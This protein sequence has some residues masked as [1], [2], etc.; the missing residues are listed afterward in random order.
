MESSNMHEHDELLTGIKKRT[1]D[2]ARFL[3]AAAW[4]RPTPT[5]NAC[6]SPEDL[7]HAE[8]LLG[9]PFPKFIRRMYIEIGNGSWGPHYGFYPLPTN[10]AKPTE[11]DL[12]GFHLEST[13]EERVLEDPFVQWPTGFVT[14]LGR[15]CVYYELCD[16]I[17]PPH[18][19]FL[20]DGDNW[21]PNKPILE[22]LNPVADS[23]ENRLERWLES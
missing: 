23:I 10:G 13:S 6:A 12:V 19:V 9:F 17:R 21:L 8:R 2:P 4:V 5:I 20:L 15:G 22:L 7:D 14:I 1:I 16:F 3:D 11:N 18:P